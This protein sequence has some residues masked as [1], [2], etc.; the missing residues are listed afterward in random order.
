MP[1]FSA[2]GTVSSVCKAIKCLPFSR[3]EEENIH[4]FNLWLGRVHTSSISAKLVSPFRLE[5]N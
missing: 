1:L 4:V 3:R 5:M 2:Y